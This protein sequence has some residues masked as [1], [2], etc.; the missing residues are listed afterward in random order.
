MTQCMQML[1]AS[2]DDPGIENPWLGARCP[3]TEADSTGG[4]T[5][6]RSG[7]IEQGDGDRD[8]AGESLAQ[9]DDD[10]GGQQQEDVDVDDDGGSG[11]GE[12]V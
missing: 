4:R 11:G 8:W 2:M 7:A 5:G 10:D 3:Q 6:G 12:Y 1:L 9:D